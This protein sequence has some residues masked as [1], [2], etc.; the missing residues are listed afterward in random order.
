MLKNEESKR[1][2]QIAGKEA[3]QLASGFDDCAGA[4]GRSPAGLDVSGSQR[5]PFNR[6][7]DPAHIKARQEGEH[8]AGRCASQARRE[9]RFSDPDS[10]WFSNN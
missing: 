1:Q 5:R 3:E 7:D 2:A 10:H 9:D 4:G 6:R 8:V